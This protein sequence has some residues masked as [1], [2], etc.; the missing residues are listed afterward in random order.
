[1]RSATER[2]MQ[3]SDWLTRW[4]AR[5]LVVMMALS[6][7]G[8]RAARAQQAPTQ[9][10][11]RQSDPSPSADAQSPEAASVSSSAAPYPDAP[12]PQ[13]QQTQNG[14]QAPP[15]DAQPNGD[16]K[17]LGTAAAPYTNPTGITGS[18]PAGAAIAPARQ[19]RVR[20]ILI[21]LGVIAAA[22][23]AVGTVAGMSHASPSRPN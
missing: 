2:T 22:G 3:H 16:Q 7:D 11:A 15:G 17:P 19:R 12:E 5:G 21:S 14:Q 1:M 20:A 4:I 9:A 8:W 13:N 10:A 6:C 23:I 18:R